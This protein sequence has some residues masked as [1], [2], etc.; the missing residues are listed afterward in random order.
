MDDDYSSKFESR[1]TRAIP[2]ESLKGKKKAAKRKTAIT[3][4]G[5]AE[6]TSGV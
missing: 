2:A 1:L 4:L 6:L 5:G 3:G